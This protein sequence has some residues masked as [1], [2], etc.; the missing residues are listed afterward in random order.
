MA[1]W[2]VRTGKHSR[3]ERK[4]LE[5]GRI[6][7]TWDRFNYDLRQFGDRAAVEEALAKV[8]PASSHGTLVNWSGQLWSFSHDMQPDD[9]VAVPLRS[10]PAIAFGVITGPYE[11]DSKAEDPYFHSH[12]VKWLNMGVPR[13]VLDQ[14]LLHC[15]GAYVTVCEVKDNDAEGRVR[16]L[17]KAG[18]TH[19]GA[20]PQRSE[21][22]DD[23]EEVTLERLARDRI[24]KL[25]A[26]KFRGPSMALLVEAL[27]KAQGYTTFRSP[28]GP[29]QGVDILAAP[30]PLGFG[31][32]RVAVQV[33]SSDA[34][35]DRPTLH[36]LVGALQNGI[37]ERGLLVSW[38]GFNSSI[39]RETAYDF[40][41]VRLWDQED[42][43]D[44]LLEQYARLD[45]DLR[46][47]LPLKRIWTVASHEEE[48]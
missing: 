25:L 7:A 24:A 1:L 34:P 29:V 37:A 33:K 40:F 32:P 46:A 3:H 44:Q 12:K 26:S 10:R 22:E 17:A 39:D 6:Y 15:F 16:A 38:G 4:F 45:E 41:H 42:L 48:G 5:S 20:G 11:Y 19:T 47:E 30:G 2:L 8:F 14:D 18:W 27:L 28:E 31:E 13:S 43:I 9:W 36:Q 21:S 23:R 35:V